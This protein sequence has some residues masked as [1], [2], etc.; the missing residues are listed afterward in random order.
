MASL[1][2]ELEEKSTAIELNQ[3]QMVI[4]RHPDCAIQI[5]NG[6]VS[7][8][9][10]QIVK[11]GGGFFLEDLGSR[12][13]T[14][15]NDDRITERVKLTH[16]D[17]LKFG[18]AEARFEDSASAKQAP[19]AFDAAQM[20]AGGLGGV[21]VGDRDPVPAAA[22]ATLDIAVDAESEATITGALEN[23]GRF[24]VLDVN[25]E[26]KLKAV[27][28]ISS[29]LAGTV[30]LK[31]LLPKILDTLFNIFKYA[32]RGC[33]LLKNDETG[34][35]IPAAFKHRR[36]GEDAT[37][38]LSRT[39][40]NKVLEEK[41]G[42]LSADAA[43]DSQFQ[44]SES[45]SD[46]KIRSMMC[47]PLLSLAGEPMGLI[48]IDSQNPLGQF[49]NDDLEILV[50]VAGQAALSYESA[51]LLESYVAKQKQDNEMAIAQGVQRAL[52]PTELP[53][54]E[55][56]EFFASY[57][58][59][60]AV[61]GDYYDCF[62]LGEGKIV[63]SFGDVAGKGVPGALIMSRMSSCVQ[64]TLQHV[65]DVEEAMFAINNHMCDSAVEGRFVT[66]V[67]C[68]VDTNTHEVQL[69]NAGH[70]SPVIRKA[71]GTI[72]QFDTED[73]VGPPIGVMDDYPY[74]VETKSLDPGDIVVIVTD[75]VDEAMNAKGEFYGAE[76]TIDFI[77]NGPAK[78]DE[79][80]KALLAD[81]RKHA[82][83]HPQNDDITIMAFGRNPE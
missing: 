46:L 76:R 48:S 54:A 62:D 41:A 21:P 22:T 37:V 80:G 73:L 6:T 63:L 71:D 11:D 4:G 57:D 61:G 68:K 81:V 24:G 9:H 12:N 55:G 3:N 17:L 67:L 69:S 75:G 39:I 47:V 19:S 5:V 45:I 44:G 34:E 27:L 83:G 66:Y 77:K 43:A 79:L 32:D 50:V 78:A 42:I 25:P 16:N 38:R 15:I 49:T 13:G 20:Q 7:G 10:A 18:Q 82:A 33:I 64:S 31:A 1:V 74:E 72:D 23:K 26:A 51:K 14:A 8:K 59:A 53:Q 56:Y 35:M 2:F 29:S 28:D 36:E 30:D 58:S 60:Q 70:M 65:Q 52:L 40:V